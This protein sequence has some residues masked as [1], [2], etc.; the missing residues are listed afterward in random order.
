MILQLDPTIPL[1]TPKGPALAHFLVDYG[2]EH[3][4]LW[5]CALDEGGECWTFQNPEIRFCANPSM[6]RTKGKTP[7]AFKG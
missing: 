4:W 6:G 5:V 3:H 2:P 7:K 1:I